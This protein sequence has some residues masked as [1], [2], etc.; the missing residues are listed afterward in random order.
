MLS[1]ESASGAYPVEAV[2][3]M[4]KIILRVERDSL[5][6]SLMMADPPTHEKTSSDAI[7]AAAARSPRRSTRPRS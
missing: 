6:R 1:A 5:H 2:T 3:I 4:E 7:A